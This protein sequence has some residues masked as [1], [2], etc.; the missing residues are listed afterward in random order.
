[1]KDHMNF[2]NIIVGFSDSA[3]VVNM[4]V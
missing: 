4:L 2:L 3:F 1:M